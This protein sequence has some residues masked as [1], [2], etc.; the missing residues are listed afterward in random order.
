MKRGF[1]FVVMAALAV[2]MCWGAAFFSPSEALARNVVAV[3][4]AKFD[5]SVSLADNLKNYM[6]K[7][8]YVHL[9]SGK[10][11]Q[12]NVKAVGSNL[13]HLEKLA[14]KDFYDALIRIDEITAMEARFREMK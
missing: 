6:G 9:K 7:D 10:V 13:V 14:G 12:G 4:G 1:W 2:T 8:V 11:L 3:E 5:T